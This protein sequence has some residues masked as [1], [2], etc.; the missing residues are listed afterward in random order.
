[1]QVSLQAFDATP[2]YLLYFLA[3]GGTLSSYTWICMIIN[4]LQNRSPPVLPA[5][6][7]RPHLMSNQGGVESK[8]ADNLEVL[9]GYGK[10]NKESLGD[11]IFHFFR[12]YGHEFDYNN[13]VVSV[14]N[15]KHVSKFDKG[16]H[17]SNN[18]RLCIEE[19]FNTSRNLSNT[20]DDT[21]FRGL[22][23]ELRR[24]FDLISQAKLD[25]C[26]E[27]YIYPKEEERIWE[28]PPQKPKPILSRSTS[29]S[30]RGGRGGTQRG[31]RHSNQQPRNGSNNRRSSSGAFENNQTYMPQSV[32]ELNAHS[33]WLAEQARAQLHNELFTTFSV[34]QAQENSLRLQLYSQN[35]A[36]MQAQAQAYAQSHSRQVNGNSSHGNPS[37]QHAPDRNRTSSFD[38]PPQSAP[39]RTPDMYFY[40]LQYS[41]QPMSMYGYPNSS[42]SPSSPSMS[43]AVPELR[44][45]MHRS[46]ATNGSGPGGQSSS[47]LRSHSQP[48]ARSAPSPRAFPSLGISIAS[49][50][51]LGSYQPA[52]Q[53]NVS[54]MPSFMADENLEPGLGASTGSTLGTSPDEV[55]PKE[56]VGYYVSDMAPGPKK[57]AS[58]TSPTPIPTFSEIASAPTRRR[59]ST[60]QL[61]QSVLDRLKRPSRSPSPLGHDR[62]FS[63]GAQSAPL[64]AA[65]SQQGISNSNLRALNNYGTS[66]PNGSNYPVPVSIPYW[67]ATMNGS[68]PS[69]GPTDD[70]LNGQSPE[71]IL[72]GSDFYRGQQLPDQGAQRGSRSTRSDQPMVANGSTSS[73]EAPVVTGPDPPAEAPS[74]Q[75]TQKGF[76]H[77]EQLN[78]SQRLSPQARNKAIRQAQSGGMSPL[79]LSSG[80]SDGPFDEAPLLSPV[81]EVQTPSPTTARMFSPSLAQKVNESTP[82]RASRPELVTSKPGSMLG[83]QF[84]QRDNSPK[85]NGHIRGSKSESSSGAW[86]KIQKQKK[87]APSVDKGRAN[88]QPHSEKR[89]KD[90]SERKGG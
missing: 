26:C 37:Q 88:G 74:R 22:H 85:S 47:S 5:L 58:V 72:S 67:Q 68:P 87:K 65:P 50:N 63:S 11:L 16:W 14:R 27:Q 49:T 35:Q 54:T 79:D 36:M 77:T 39:I 78:G 20:A 69:L 3:F 41:G 76:M 9:E 62:A 53:P 66:I 48:A 31:G 51:G 73:K 6:H 81:Y 45:S 13:L 75:H 56:Y 24:A 61:P 42:T 80:P 18:N 60:D 38:Q 90:E 4:F 57:A 82:T 52:R 12:F 10:K 40:P 32:Q 89:P 28:R 33:S 71:H 59:L 84:K 17:L 15:G 55:T 21:S 34:L 1:M 43:S 83:D 25:E 46:T 23:I 8:F 44:R 2:I 7:Q 19:P 64:S 86:Q 70:S 30:G 29:Q